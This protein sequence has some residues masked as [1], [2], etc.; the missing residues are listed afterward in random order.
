MTHTAEKVLNKRADHQAKQS[1]AVI[2]NAF[3]VGVTT[4]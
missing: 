1:Q 3:C 2:L 4:Q